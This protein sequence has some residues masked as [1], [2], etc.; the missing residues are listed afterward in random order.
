MA[1][2]A[3]SL[4]TPD[5]MIVGGGGVA[6]IA[7]FLPWWGYSGPLGLYGSSVSGWNA[8]FTAWAGSL[9]LAAAAVYLVLHRSGVSLPSLPVGPSVAIAGAAV[10]GLALVVIRWLSLPR[11]HA[12]LAGNVGPKFG[13]WLALAAGTVEVV[14]AVMAFRASGESLPWAAPGSNEPEDEI[15]R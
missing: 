13:L 12:G 5:R 3:K 15:Q 14:G 9:L 4:N 2:D 1:F 6:L 11:V 10:V 8:G 7:S